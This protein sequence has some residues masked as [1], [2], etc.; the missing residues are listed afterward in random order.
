M[1]KPE[2]TYLKD[3]LPPSY[4]IK[5]VR[6]AFELRETESLVTSRMRFN[7]NPLCHQKEASLVLD[8][9]QL[10]LLEIKL[11]NKALSEE[12]YLRSDRN[13]TIKKVPAEFDLYLK[14]RIKPQENTS[15]EGLYKSKNLF[16]TQC[17]SQGFRKI[18]YFPDRPDVMTLFRT[19][20]VA[21]KSKYPVLLS[22]GNLISQEELGNGD[23]RVVYD[24]PFAKPSYLFA[25]VA[26]DLKAYK[27]SFKTRSG[28][29]IKLGI[30]VEE[31]H[32]NQCAHA[33]E[34]LKQSMKWDEEVYGL[35]YD[36]DQ[37]FIVAVSDFNM[38]AMENKGLNIFNASYVLARPETATDQVYEGI[39][40][41]IAHEYFHN[42]TGNRV[43]CRD[44]FQLSLKEG[45]TIFRD[46]DFSADMN[47][48]TV[49][50]IDEV[51]L[52]RNHQFLEDA[53][54]MAHPVRPES[55]I[56]INNFYTV[57]VYHKGAELIRMMYLILGKENFFKA[58]ALY[59]QRH[60]GKAVTTEDF[61]L[62]MEDASGIDL[63]QFRLWY[64]QAGTPEVKM[65]SR[66]DPQEKTLCIDFL[67]TCPKTPGQ[68]FKEPF[69]IPI[70]LGLTGKSGEPVSF[71][72]E[73]GQAQ[74]TETLLHLKE[75]KERFILNAVD[76]K[77]VVSAFRQ[78]SAP[79]RFNS[80]LSD[81]DLTHLMTYDQDGF[82][83]WDAGQRRILKVLLDLIGQISKNQTLALDPRLQEA[84]TKIILD[85]KPEASF[86]ANLL[87]L[88]SESY[89][90]QHL[91][92]IEIEAVHA[93]REFLKEELGK[94]LYG[95]FKELYMKN[96]SDEAYHFDAL[97]AGKRKLK[98]TALFF[99]AASKKP[100]AS[101]ECRAQFENSDNMTDQ[102]AAISFLSSLEC[103][104]KEMVLDAFYQKWSADDLVINSWFSIQASSRLTDLNGIKKLLKDEAYNDKN[105]NKIRSLVGT[106]CGTNLI[107]FHKKDGS[108]YRFLADEILRLDKINPQVASRLTIPFTRWKKY[109]S[110][111]QKLIVNELERILDQKSLSGDVYEIISK[112]L[113]T[114]PDQ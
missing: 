20:I 42:W 50:R 107:Q 71:H 17:E 58:M 78:F 101:R 12:E 108:G 84:F 113:P 106:F 29:E 41:V 75:K 56:E 34:S 83:R 85:D 48:R 55:Y 80:D 5:E 105:P 28:R 14:T 92:I 54:P 32:L 37:F 112:S 18:T 69:H 11:N 94:E 62:A 16:C 99:M 91:E 10:E 40:S 77:P 68:E 64:S 82:N 36:L 53:G 96:T 66:Y 31:K 38:G 23:H 2:T 19:E 51:N 25:L 8:G 44:W 3:Y 90:A 102:L 47:S 70:L 98:N 21:E 95:L 9:E 22:N 35:E 86:K 103:E 88:P 6:L 1:K 73:K 76:E 43:T 13:L 93:A 52:L 15:L 100:E 110:L 45:L 109:D 81:A 72:L 65:E 59:F 97:S 60:D 24:D 46:Q 4:L 39:Q 74:L 111:R 114:S 27:D 87:Q 30:Y 33:M 7:K 67:Q 61:V 79:V 63:K 57:T 104:E 89:I 49:K 26:G